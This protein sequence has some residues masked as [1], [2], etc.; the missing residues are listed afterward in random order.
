MHP[1][2]PIE[3]TEVC[4]AMTLECPETARSAPEGRGLSTLPTWSFSVLDPG[5]TSLEQPG[6]MDS[7]SRCV[8]VTGKPTVSGVP[9]FSAAFCWGLECA[10]ARH[11]L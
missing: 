2:E 5:W 9:G 3:S 6:L 8:V 1:M 4:S 10:L 7:Q 11:C